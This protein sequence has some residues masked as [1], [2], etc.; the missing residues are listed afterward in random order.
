MNSRHYQPVMN[1]AQG[2]CSGVEILVRWRH[3]SGGVIAPEAFVP[4]AEISGLILLLTAHLMAQVAEDLARHWNDDDGTLH[5]AFNIAAIHLRN[6]QIVKDCRQ[7]LQKVHLRHVLL[8]LELTERQCIEFNAVTR[9]VL[10]S[11]Q[12]IGVII[13]IDG[14]GTGYSGLSYWAACILSSENRSVFCRDDSGGPERHR[15][16]RRGHRSCQLLWDAGD[17]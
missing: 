9:H 14:F 6:E 15:F 7:F 5:V 12:A 3:P 8:V 10:A 1:V 2:Y 16:G 17:C 11:L 4:L 13:A